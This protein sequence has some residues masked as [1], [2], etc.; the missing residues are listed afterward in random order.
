MNNHWTSFLN[1]IDEACL[2][3]GCRRPGDPTDSGREPWFRGQSNINY[4]LLPSLFRAYEEPDQEDRRHIAWVES[5]F[6]YDFAARARELRESNMNDWDI[7]FA[8]QHYGVPTRLLD[9]TDVLGVALY[10]S[11]LD[12]DG[13][14]KSPCVWVMNP[15]G[16]NH[17]RVDDL[18][19]PRFLPPPEDINPSW[20]YGQVVSQWKGM[21]WHKPLA[22]YPRHRTERVVAQSGWFTIHGND[23]RSLEEI[24]GSKVVIRV[25]LPSEARES[26]LRFMEQAGINRRTLFPDMTNLAV[27][28]REQYG[29]A[30]GQ[31]R[32]KP[33]G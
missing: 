4:K 12:G 28:L 2:A 18:F 15:Y 30:T 1:R 33:G 5:E 24:A 32:K 25:D 10:F 6:F 21:G 29:Y 17:P 8:M 13:I 16:L 19:D 23:H 3:L 20:E 27:Y 11:L 22:L 7:L 14:A 26:G 31:G 9:W